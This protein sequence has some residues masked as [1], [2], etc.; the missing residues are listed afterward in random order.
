MSG[1]WINRQWRLFATAVAF[2][3]RLPIPAGEY[4]PRVLAQSVVYFPVVGLL[5]ALIG[6]AVFLL[7]NALW[8]GPVALLLLL[9]SS[10]L[11]TGAFHE[12]GLADTVDGLGGGWSTEDKLRIMKD[13]RVGTYGALALVMALLLKFGGLMSLPS[14]V[15]PAALVCGHVLGRW[16]ILPLLR[17]CEYLGGDRGTGGSFAGAVDG[18]GLLIGTLPAWIL[19]ALCAP[20][21]PLLVILC[22]VLLVAVCRQ[23]FLSKLGGITGDTL[24]ATNQ[25]VEVGVYLVLAAHFS[26]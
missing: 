9:L 5:V 23:V 18:R 4:E 12:D 20:V 11:V 25:V 10:L 21:R 1:S 14:E 8:G 16:A 19:V 3:T 22:A 2:L 6:A 15:V 13:S 26:Q 7:A 17:Y 24:G